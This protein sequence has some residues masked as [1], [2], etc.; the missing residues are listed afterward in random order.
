[1]KKYDLLIVGAGPAGLTAAIYAKRSNLNT[2]VVEK[3]VP[4][5]KVVTTATVENYPGYSEIA[6]PDLAFSFYD[7]CTKLGVDFE[8]SEVINI[9]TIDNDYK[10]VELSSGEKIIAKAVV[11]ATGMINRKLGIPNEEKFFNKG[12]SYCAICDGS[13]FKNKR[14]AVIGSGRSAV[15]ESIFLSDIVSEVHLISNKPEFKADKMIVDKLATIP[16]IKTYMNTATLSFNGKDK[17]ESVS[18]EKIDSKEKFDLE[19]EGAFIFIGFLPLAPTINKESIL[20]S[21]TR[22]IRPNEKME[23]KIHGIFS[24]GDI[25]TKSYRQISTAISDGTVAALSALEYI[26]FIQWK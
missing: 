21:E 10:E 17:L 1:M 19:L 11:I 4:G 5:G 9:N 14:V 2:I 7:Q 15:E 20:D 23:T 22:F 6:G 16:N 25:N 13:L 18:F 12:I 24:A 3:N 8:Y 26:S